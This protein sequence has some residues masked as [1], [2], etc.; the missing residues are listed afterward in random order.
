MKA[1][2]L[3]NSVK[4]ASKAKPMIVAR[5]FI[6]KKSVTPI[7]KTFNPINSQISGIR[8]F[9]EERGPRKRWGDREEKPLDTNV[10]LLRVPVGV[11]I[12]SALA[13]F[14]VVENGVT[15]FDTGASP[16]VF[17]EFA[18]NEDATRAQKFIRSK[19][20]NPASDLSSTSAIPS[21]LTDIETLRKQSSKPTTTAVVPKV[22]FYF[23]EADFKEAFP[24]FKFTNLV[25]GHGKAYVEF[26]TVEEL[27]KFVEQS[28]VATIGKYPVNIYKSIGFDMERHAKQP[29]TTIKIRG[30]SSDTTEEDV[31]SFL[32]GL[33]VTR[34]SPFSHEI[35][36]GRLITEFYVTLGDTQSVEAALGK[37][38]EKIGSRWVSV[39][40]SS[41]REIKRAITKKK[42]A[43]GANFGD[44][45]EH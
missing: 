14:G 22:P 44:N 35:P 10:L 33:N 34:V 26:A 3:I 37:D 36:G 12:S 28:G 24:G 21:S 38:R 2:S 18:S 45:V 20:R 41:P 5:S 6:T 31:R 30:A 11:D 13:S 17:V 25:V 4:I 43:E 19:A 39:K 7:T 9:S 23:G 8:Q 40:R 16:Y 32:D 1:V 27:E 15:T 29:V 42:E